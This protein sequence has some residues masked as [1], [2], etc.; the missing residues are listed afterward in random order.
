MQNSV[1]KASTGCKGGHFEVGLCTT[2]VC[3]DH[4]STSS[5]S[6]PRQIGVRLVLHNNEGWKKV[7]IA[8]M[9][10]KFVLQHR[11]QHRKVEH[12]KPPGTSGDRDYLS[13]L[14]GTWAM[15]G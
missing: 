4:R 13:W 1:I 6:S 10:C 9:V 15:L 3:L 2:S 5:C 7:I 12:V 14:R 8:E 11:K